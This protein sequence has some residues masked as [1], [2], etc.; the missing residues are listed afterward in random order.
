MADSITRKREVCKRK[1]QCE[2]S[3]SAE[4]SYQGAMSGTKRHANRKAEELEKLCNARFA[5]YLTI[6]KVIFRS[7]QRTRPRP[8]KASSSSKKCKKLRSLTMVKKAEPFRSVSL[9]SWLGEVQLRFLRFLTNQNQ[10]LDFG[11]HLPTTSI[12]ECK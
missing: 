2:N 1:R 8:E 6:Q 7:G 11:G 4:E 5:L 9:F 12:V 10:L 3:F